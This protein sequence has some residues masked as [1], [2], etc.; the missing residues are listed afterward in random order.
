MNRNELTPDASPRAAFGARLRSLREARGWTLD[1]LSERMEYSASHISG[2]ENANRAPTVKFAQRADRALELMGTGETLANDVF[3]IKSGS[4]L[5]GFPEYVL[6][7]GRAAEVRYFETGIIPGLLQ[8]EAYAQA[9]AQSA[10]RRGTITAEQAHERVTV[11]AE[12]QDALRRTPAPLV[13]AVLDESC[14]RRPIGT[15]A[16]WD[17]QLSRL[18]EFAE[19]PDT[20]FQLA[21]FSM[22]VRRAFNLPLY[23]LT[24]A[25]RSIVAYAESATRGHLERDGKFVAPILS[26]YYQLQ[27]HALS[28]PDSVA[29]IRQIREGMS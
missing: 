2:V 26:T 3:R 27:A 22:G 24:M 6:S 15:V 11:V 4:L 17:T 16:E 12:R 25:D 18:I 14:V 1:D 20:V 28:Q 7:E 5:E 21:P 19:Q 29:M 23:I 10:V 9:L 13:M 8:T